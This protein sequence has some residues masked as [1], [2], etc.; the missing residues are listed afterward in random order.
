[1]SLKDRIQDDMKSAMRAKAK[2]RLSTLRL[3][4]AAIKQ[5]EVDRQTTLDD[6][7][8]ITVL[9][10]MIKQRRESISHYQNANRQELAA[11][12][13]SEIAV[14]QVYMPEHLS[15]E[16][17]AALIDEAIS[18]TKAQS[19]RDMG[20]VMSIVKQRAHGRADMT[21]VSTLVKAKLAG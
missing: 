7:Q 4:L 12:E 9:E 2:D 3:I 20:K 15:D 6:E 16:E 1:M 8:I 19:M 10:R 5:Q 18:M 21:T 11:Q 13:S 14:I 17:V